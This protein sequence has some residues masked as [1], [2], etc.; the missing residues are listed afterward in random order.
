MLSSTRRRLRSLGDASVVANFL[1]MLVVF[2]SVAGGNLRERLLQVANELCVELGLG[3]QGARAGAA[4]Q[5]SPTFNAAA[6]GTRAEDEV[7]V[8]GIRQA[9]EEMVVEL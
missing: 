2:E 7:L 4:I 8:S 3:E 5:S 6:M 9:L 1:E